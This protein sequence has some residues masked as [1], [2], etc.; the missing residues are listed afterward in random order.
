MRDISSFTASLF[1]FIF[2]A[3]C[4]TLSVSHAFVIYA[5]GLL[6]SHITPTATSTTHLHIAYSTSKSV[7]THIHTCTFPH[8]FCKYL[9]HSFMCISRFQLWEMNDT[10]GKGKLKEMQY[11][12]KSNFYVSQWIH[13]L[14]L[15]MFSSECTK[16]QREALM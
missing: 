3:R 15:Q 11:F 1:S 13:F 10:K 16:L 9:H 12:K 5:L 8:L 2:Q 4:F 6:G 7:C 14:L